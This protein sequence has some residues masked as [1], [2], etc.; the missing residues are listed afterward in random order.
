MKFISL[1]ILFNLIHV[2]LSADSRTHLRQRQIEG[3][4]EGDISDE[5]VQDDVKTF[6]ST[7]NYPVGVT[8]V[9][10]LSTTPFTVPPE[11]DFHRAQFIEEIRVL[12]CVIT[13]FIISTVFILSGLKSMSKG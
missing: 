6:S 8:N 2:I 13:C 9:G 5:E 4:I 12:F 3:D 1:L 10:R 11:H 7:T